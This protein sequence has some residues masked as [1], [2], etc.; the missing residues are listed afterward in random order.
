MTT[1]KKRKIL[2]TTVLLV[3]TL[4][5]LDSGYWLFFFVW[6]SAAQPESNSVWMP[7]IYG[8]L[9]AGVVSGAVWVGAVV[10]LVRNRKKSPE[11]RPPLFN[12]PDG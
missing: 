11:T 2:W 12:Y 3:S 1:A 8:W 4:I 6:M 9:A 7:R 5:G 10:W